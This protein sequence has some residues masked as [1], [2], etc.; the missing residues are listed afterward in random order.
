MDKDVYDRGMAKR[1]AVLG[2]AYVDKAMAN[3]DDFNRD[4]QRI[5]TQYC[6]GEAWGDATL[7]PRERSILNLGMIACLGKMH[8]FESHFRGAINNG[9]STDELR[10]VLTQIAVYCGIPVGVDC[11][12][13]GRQVLAQIEAEPAGKGANKG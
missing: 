1:R 10:A 2:D 12:R 4:F 5:V 9:L 3:V 13:V 7:S 6:W 11:F 8:E